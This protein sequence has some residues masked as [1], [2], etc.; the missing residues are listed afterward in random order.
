MLFTRKVDELL[1]AINAAIDTDPVAALYVEVLRLIRVAVL[2]SLGSGEVATLMSRPTPEPHPRL[3]PL[4][5]HR[6][7]RARTNRSF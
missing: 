1:K 7:Q 5:I 2:K 3:V 4:R 6:L